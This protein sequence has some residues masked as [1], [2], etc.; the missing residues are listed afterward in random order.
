MNIKFVESKLQNV[1]DDAYH[2]LDLVSSS[3]IKSFQKS[4]AHFQASKNYVRKPSKALDLGTL[5]HCAVLEPEKFKKTYTHFDGDKRT[6]AYKDFSNLH[7]T[8]KIVSSEDYFLAIELV[9]QIA[10]HDVASNLLS[11][12]LMEKTILFTDEETGLGC[13]SRFDAINVEK[14]LIVDLKTT[15]DARPWNFASSCAKYDYHIQQAFYTMA[16]HS[17][18][19]K[20]D[21][22]VFIAVEKER[23]YGIGCYR[24]SKI[25]VEQAHMIV[26]TSLHGFKKCIEDN[27]W[28][29][30][31]SQIVEL[32]LPR[33]KREL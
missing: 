29:S 11:G 21:D 14:G 13:K 3:G 16:A 5:I 17:I 33:Y 7:P 15:E 9:E 23:P 27:S 24:L 26:R 32:E 10:K 25:D 18:G 2:K 28:P 1:E 31:T 19:M 20:V 8:K 4:P 22:F 30:Y 12:C 6:N